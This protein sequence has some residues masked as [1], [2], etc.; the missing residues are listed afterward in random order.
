[1]ADTLSNVF[2]VMNVARSNGKSTCVLGPNSKLLVKVLEIIKENKYIKNFEVIND[3][4]GGF[5]KVELSDY[6]NKCKAIRPRLPIKSEEITKYEKRFL[7][8]IGFG[9]IILSTNKGLMTNKD[10]KQQRVG[11]TLV[12]YVY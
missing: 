6:M 11:G 4:R 1:M 2:N 10:A 5:I 8:S 12:A 3:A 7:P 9:I